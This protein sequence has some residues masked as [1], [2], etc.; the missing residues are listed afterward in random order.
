MKAN[1]DPAE[2]GYTRVATVFNGSKNKFGIS[3]NSP[4]GHSVIAGMKIGCVI[5]YITRN[6]K[7]IGLIFP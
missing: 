3:G 2:N 6:G 5:L 7:P 4:V 1:H